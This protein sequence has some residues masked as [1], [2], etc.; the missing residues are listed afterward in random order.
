M[1][2][3]DITI[4][5]ERATRAATAGRLAYD[6][7]PEPING[8]QY[9]PVETVAILGKLQ[10]EGKRTKDTILLWIKKGKIPVKLRRVNKLLHDAKDP[11]YQICKWC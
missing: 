3:S 8:L 6:Y 9:S 1:Q 11:S 7:F 4:E 10:K 5:R 2:P